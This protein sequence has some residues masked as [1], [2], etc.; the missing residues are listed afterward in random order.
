MTS[1]GGV[2][3][4]LEKEIPVLENLVRRIEGPVP[5]P[6]KEAEVA[7]FLDAERN[8]I[9]KDKELIRAAQARN[10]G[11]AERLDQ[12]DAVLVTAAN[13]LADEP[14]MTECGTNSAF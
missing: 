3:R 4:F 11:L 2:V 7:A 8:V 10:E 9:E 5:P 6:G 1:I 13:D 12:E 14:G